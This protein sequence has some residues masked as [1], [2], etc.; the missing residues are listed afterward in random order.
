[1]ELNSGLSQQR[2]LSKR[3]RIFS[4]ANWTSIE[5]NISKALYLERSLLQRNLE[6]SESISEILGKFGN[7]VLGKAGE[8]LLG[9]KCEK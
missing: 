6:T 3:R 4:L 9:R 7:V 1:V 2:Q 5:G 8:E